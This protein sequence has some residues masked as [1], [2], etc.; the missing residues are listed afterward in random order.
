MTKEKLIELGIT[1]ELATKVIESFGEMI[2][3]G[4]FTEVVE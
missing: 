1:E 2:P 3:Q 4:R